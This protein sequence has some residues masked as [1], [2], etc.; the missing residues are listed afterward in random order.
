MPSQIYALGPGLPL[1][2]EVSWS[3]GWRD[4]VV[5]FDGLEIGRLDG[6]YDEIRL[7]RKLSLPDGSALHV[8]LV[9]ESGPLGYAEELHVYVNGKPVPGSAAI[10]IPG[11]AYF[12][13]LTCVLVPVVSQGGAVPTVI[14]LGGAAGCTK[15]SRDTTLPVAKRVLLC[16]AMTAGAW[17]VFGTLASLAASTGR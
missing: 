2:L 7:G 15:L 13:I 16:A 5:R 3:V 1:Q 11:W 17:G 12:F 6:G 14:G 8:Q 4:G 10:P 9:R